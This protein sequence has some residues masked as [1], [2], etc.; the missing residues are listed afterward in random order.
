MTA[1]GLLAAIGISAC[2]ST[3]TTPTEAASTSGPGESAAPVLAGTDVESV[4]AAGAEEGELEYWANLSD[5]PFARFIAPFEERY[6]DIKVTLF[7][8]DPSTIVEQ[9]ITADT[10]GQSVAADGISGTPDAFLALT[11]RG[12]IANVDWSALGLSETLENPGLPGMFRNVRIPAGL[13]F[14]SDMLT[15][16]DLPSTWEELIDEK[17]AGRR[18][19]THSTGDPFTQL[20]LAWGEEETVDYV[21]RLSETTQPVLA[22]GITATLETVASG[23]FQLYTWGRAAEVAEQQAAGAPIDV[24]YLDFIPVSDQYV[25][26]PAGAEHPNAAA[27][28][29][30]WEQSEEGLAQLYEVDFKKNEDAPVGVPEGAEVVFIDSAEDV[31]LSAKV[32]PQLVEVLAP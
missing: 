28:F 23:E 4:C 11:E 26:I 5:E 16:D 6:P 15:A 18:L 24:K 30:L 3:S 32:G 10:A 29:L 14:N 8:A 21:R 27:C 31:E 13:A 9:M 12:L 22:E 19:A 17:W 25:G 7:Q 2:G 20:V 1:L